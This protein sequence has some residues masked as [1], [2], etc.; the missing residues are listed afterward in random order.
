[1][2]KSDSFVVDIAGTGDPIIFLHGLGSTASVWEPQTR[3]LSDK[4][5]TIRYDLAGSGRSIRSGTLSVADW[6][7]DLETILQSRAIDRAR[8][9][10]HSLGTL[11]L[12]HFAVK[13]PD[14]VLGMTLIGINRGPN[15]QR[16]KAMRDRAARVRSEGLEAIVEG[17]AKGTLSSHSFSTK[18]ELIGFVREL[19]LRQDRE[20]YAISCEAAASAEAVDISKIVCPVLVIS[21]ADDSVSPPETGKAAADELPNGRFALV[22]NCGHWQPIE[23]PTQTTA[24]IGEFFSR[25]GLSNTL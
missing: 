17:V 2:Q 22:E 1:M 8:F 14:V 7:K 19:L 25:L 20:S 16:R 13:H 24:L 12:Q 23:Q 15:E 21:G 9:V 4:C 3:Y 5:T 11:V 6:V 10:G 18:P